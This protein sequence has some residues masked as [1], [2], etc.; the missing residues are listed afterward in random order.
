MT[1][2]PDPVLVPVAGYPPVTI[3][4]EGTGGD[5]LIVLS[6]PRDEDSAA[7]GHDDAVTRLNAHEALHIAEALTNHARHLIRSADR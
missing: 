4:T 5:P 3:E 2:Y 6:I 7:D 1:T